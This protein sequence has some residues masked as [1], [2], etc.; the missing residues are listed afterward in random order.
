MTARKIA[1]TMC[2]G[3][4]LALPSSPLIGQG[5]DSAR[6]RL[7]ERV[8][9]SQAAPPA[10]KP[11]V[12]VPESTFV[13]VVSE[14]PLKLAVA[15][16]QRARLAPR[17]IMTSSG[18]KVT[19]GS[20]ISQ[21]P[22]AGA[23][24]PIGSVVAIVIDTTRV[25]TTSV[26]STRVGAAPTT[27]VP[28]VVGSR[29]K[30]ALAKLEGDSLL[31]IVKVVRRT[32]LSRAV[33]ANQEPMA[34]ARVSM[35]SRVV[36]TIVIDSTTTVPRVVGRD[37][38]GVKRAIDEAELELVVQQG[39]D[40]NVPA[41]LASNQDPKAGTRIRIGSSVTVTF[42]TGV[43]PIAVPNVRDSTREGAERV[44]VAAA[45]RVANVDTVNATT[46]FGRVVRQ[47]PT[48]GAMVPPRSTV[49][50][51]I[52][53]RD[54]DSPVRVPSVLTMTVERGDG[55]LTKLRLRLHVDGSRPDAAP[56]ST[57]IQQ[58][59]APGSTAPPGSEVHVWTASPLPP[60][61]PDSAV[62]PSVVGL[63]RDSAIERLGNAGFSIG[64]QR[65]GG[66]GTP[67]RVGS[68]SLPA[69]RKDTVGARVAIWVVP[70]PTIERTV[71][72]DVTHQFA[73]SAIAA[74]EA[75]RLEGHLSDHRA[76]TEPADWAVVG[77]TPRA[78]SRVRVRSSVELVVEH[79]PQFVV[80]PDVV[81][82]LRQHAERLVGEVGLTLNVL[83][84]RFT[85]HLRETVVTQRI[86]AGESVLRGS[87]IPVEMSRPLA[88]PL[89]A[90]V[91]LLGLATVGVAKVIRRP[92]PKIPLSFEVVPIIGETPIPTLDVPARSDLVG[93][94]LSL[95]FAVDDV[96]GYTDNLAGSITLDGGPDA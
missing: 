82:S 27:L 9:V 50:L 77:Q 5:K 8:S 24:V 66:Q 7:S 39:P 74:L 83:E 19:P 13:P 42:S 53:R 72:P 68:Q 2:A 63:T 38:A 85:F 81:N 37:E 46:G 17:V 58:D 3:A 14:R 96:R 89:A 52:G 91:P 40:A 87:R 33:V 32:D 71:V 6:R 49:H 65:V 79:E 57:I 29:L 56:V 12:I 26:G 95:Q 61:P 69:G 80:V 59:P 62:I 10:A 45:L 60:P 94:S 23:R 25:N 43:P 4:L 76:D 64:A 30:V 16:I 93:P 78:G 34:G 47:E 84:H 22:A 1:R 92:R 15:I 11:L 28:N 48:A 35:R 90:A 20:V 86:A 55:L 67:G 31:G 18:G 70:R 51:D 36:L 88:W 54:P 44:I 41:G 73:D 75:A 21:K